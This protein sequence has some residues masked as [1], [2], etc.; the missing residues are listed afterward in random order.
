MTA[1]RIAKTAAA[2]A[3]SIGAAVAV[4]A[5][6][7]LAAYDPHGVDQLDRPLAD[8]PQTTLPAVL[9]Q[10]PAQAPERGN[11]LWGISIESLHATRERPLFA[12]SR[13]PPSPAPAAALPAAKPAPVAPVVDQPSLDLL[14][15][16]VG[17]GSGYAVFLN[18]STRG[19]VRLRTGEGNNGWILQSVTD[20]EA[21]LEKDNRKVVVHLPSATGGQK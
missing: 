2:S 16:V 3:A 5:S 20:R 8:T 12:P 4:T 21:V 17:G 11:P 18:N 15:I 6:L 1:R 10:V 19:I 14:G 9:D 7:A 13:R